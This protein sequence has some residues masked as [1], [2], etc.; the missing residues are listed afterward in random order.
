MFIDFSCGRWRFNP[1]GA[2]NQNSLAC[3]EKQLQ[4]A[5]HFDGRG[6]DHAAY[7]LK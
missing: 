7:K 4:I 3:K 1:A 2:N 5:K 6:R